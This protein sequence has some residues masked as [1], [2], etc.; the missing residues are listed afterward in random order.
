MD[1]DLI[2]L[3]IMMAKECLSVNDLVEKSNL[4]RATV[5]KIIN[6]KQKPSTKSLGLIAKAL[7]ADVTEFIITE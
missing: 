6:G 7:N 1:I 5:S 2:K 3:K 4:G